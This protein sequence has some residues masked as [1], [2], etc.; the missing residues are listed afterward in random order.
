MTPAQVVVTIAGAALAVGVNVYFFAPRHGRA[1]RGG[2]ATPRDGAQS[3]SGA[4][5]MPDEGGDRPR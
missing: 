4:L 5:V 3:D 1:R 2:S